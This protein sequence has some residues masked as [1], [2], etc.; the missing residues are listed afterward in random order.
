[1][2]CPRHR[3]TV[4]AVLGQVPAPGNL[5]CVS[6]RKLLSFASSFPRMTGQRSQELHVL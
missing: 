1:M 2:G 4:L 3:G 6:P 5:G